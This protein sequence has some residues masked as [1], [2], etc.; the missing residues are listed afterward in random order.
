MTPEELLLRANP[1]WTAGEVPSD[2][3]KPFRRT[4]FTELAGYL[5]DR[6]V[7]VVRG[8]RRTGKT[9]LLFQLADH[10]LREGVP[11]RRVIYYS[12][13]D[14]TWE[15]ASLARYVEEAVVRSSL[16]AAGRLYL[17]LDEVQHLKQWAVQV[18]QFYDLY[19]NLK[20]VVT[21]SASLGIEHAA[22]ESLAG[23]SYYFD[24]N[25][26]SF[27]EYLALAHNLE[28]R[29]DLRLWERELSPLL[30]QYLARGL[31]EIVAEPDEE[32]VRRYLWEGV[33]ERVLY[34]DLPAQYDVR[35]P[36]LLRDLLLRTLHRPGWYVNLDSLSRD[37]H[38]DRRTIGRYLGYLEYAC[39]VRTVA[40]YRGSL[41]ATSR[42][43]KRAYP[44]HPCLSMGA[45]GDTPER[46]P[47]LV[48]AAVGSHLGAGHY[49]RT[50][51][52]EVDF[53]V[54]RDGKPLAVEVKFLGQPVKPRDLRGLRAF[55]RRFPE[56]E[57]LVVTRNQWEDWQLE[58]RPVRLRPS[59]AVLLDAP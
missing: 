9:T 39:L 59:W 8:L 20:F 29:D 40:N 4:L 6:Q 25:P 3:L 37:L 22:R 49:W 41:A 42:K 43:L 57:G 27:R 13:D 32:R 47:L 51:R 38:R 35:D 56:S 24:L 14:L 5:A 1:W 11:P 7:L 2:L 33:T 52:H 50:N 21:G 16:R 44:I 26:L 28:P 36:E 31:P 46:F 18:K 15:L 45:F 53:V 54:F 55:L 34:R 19:P 10:L 23:R 17:L 48:E 58:G 30:G 12:F